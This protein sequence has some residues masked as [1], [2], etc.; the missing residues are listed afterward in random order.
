MKDVEDLG[1]E[2][3]EAAGVKY[4]NAPRLWVGRLNLARV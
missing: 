2:N 1:A 3:C 4:R